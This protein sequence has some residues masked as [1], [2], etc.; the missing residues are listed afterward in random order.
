ML[1]PISNSQQ[2]P[3]TVRERDIIGPNLGPIIIP[4]GREK[5]ADIVED[6]DP[7]EEYVIGTS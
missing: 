2:G 3:I 6:I 5:G 7:K 1:G 4:D